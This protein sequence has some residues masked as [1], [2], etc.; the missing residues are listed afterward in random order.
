MCLCT[1]GYSA[2]GVCVCV[3]LCGRAKER[4]TMCVGLFVSLSCDTI[5]HIVSHVSVYRYV[6][7][8][9]VSAASHRVAR[10]G[11]RSAVYKHTLFI[12]RIWPYLLFLL[13]TN[14]WLLTRMH[15][16]ISVQRRARAKT[17][18]LFHLGRNAN[19]SDA[20][21]EEPKDNKLR[22]YRM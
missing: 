1:V 21:Y 10:I 7:V 5:W 9:D 16:W 13:H 4:R 22:R 17:S 3:Y 12:Y 6:H 2:N 15:K 18:T 20:K 14:I 11:E 19:K 8:S